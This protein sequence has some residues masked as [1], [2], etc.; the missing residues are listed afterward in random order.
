MNKYILKKCQTLAFAKSFK[1]IPTKFSS[2]EMQNIYFIS[3]SKT[4]CTESYAKKPLS[5]AQIPN[6]STSKSIPL[7]IIELARKQ[8]KT[9]KKPT[10]C[11]DSDKYIIED[12]DCSNFVSNIFTNQNQDFLNDQISEYKQALVSFI[13]NPE[14]LFEKSLSKEF[15]NFIYYIY[16][17]LTS[18]ELKL[19]I[20]KLLNNNDVTTIE[21]ESKN[22]IE[23]ED[24]EINAIEPI[25]LFSDIKI[26]I[27]EHDSNSSSSSKLYKPDKDE[28]KKATLGNST[29]LEAFSKNKF[30]VIHGKKS[31]NI[32]DYIYKRNHD[33]LNSLARNGVVCAPSVQNK[34]SIQQLV[35]KLS[36]FEKFNICFVHP[37]YELK[38]SRSEYPS[39]L[40][41]PSYLINEGELL[42]IVYRYIVINFFGYCSVFSEGMEELEY[43][44]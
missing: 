17:N 3:D 28:L 27:N 5:I 7:F 37:S 11:S 31:A 30:T 32:D 21:L 25:S 22:P 16:P 10:E 35:D 19:N 44:I 33:I 26:V 1:Y 24:I 12:L 43:L 41:E 40:I 18:S 6:K 34:L 29:Q 23:Y 15:L 4:K 36:C 42:A 2:S 9:I 8:T 14:L 20:L 39:E 13:S 38:I